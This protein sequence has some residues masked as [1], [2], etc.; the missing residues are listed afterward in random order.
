MSKLRN[1]FYRRQFILTAQSIDE[2]GT[3]SDDDRADLKRLIAQLEDDSLAARV[4]FLGRW[5]QIRRSRSE[6]FELACSRALGIW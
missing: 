3:L 2:V 1:G 5:R 6:G 4:S